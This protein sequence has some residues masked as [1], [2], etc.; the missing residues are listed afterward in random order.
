MDAS[1]LLPDGR[2]CNYGTCLLGQCKRSKPSHIR[3]FFSFIEKLD[4]SAL[5]EFMKSNIVGTVIILSLVIWIPASWTI[6]C[7][8]KRHERKIRNDPWLSDEALLNASLQSPPGE[9]GQR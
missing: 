6:S 4:S 8:D 2:P 5:L 3:R 7:L 9:D 1:K